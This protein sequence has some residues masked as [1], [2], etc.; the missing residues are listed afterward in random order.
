M[1]NNSRTQPFDEI[2]NRVEEYFQ[3]SLR[4]K[5]KFLNNRIIIGNLNKIITIINKCF[6]NGNKLIIAGNGGSASQAQHFAGEIVGRYKKERKAYPAIS[7]T[8]DS[9]ILTAWSNDYNFHTVFSRQI[10]AFGKKGDVFF[11][12]STS[13]NSNNIIESVKKAKQI[14]IKTMCLLGKNG[15]KLKSL[16]DISIIIESQNT[17]RIQ[18]EHIFI[19]HIICEEIEKNFQ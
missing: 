5:N 4:I 1:T 6:Q 17:P 12:L 2:Q 7:L 8:A 11:G 9:T 19:I 14:G 16:A 3:E 10:E 15:G 13:G 18:E